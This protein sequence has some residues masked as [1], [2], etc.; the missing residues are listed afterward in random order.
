MTRT[1]LAALVLAPALL[2]GL[3]AAAEPPPAPEPP[4]RYVQDRWRHTRDTATLGVVVGGLG[5]ATAATGIALRD[6]D[7]VPSGFMIGTGA[8]AAA[9]GATVM[10]VVGLQQRYEFLDRANSPVGGY[11]GL[12]MVGLAGIG[13][14]G[15]IAT[16]A[17]SEVHET[18]LYGSAAIGGTAL[19][20]AALQLASNSSRFHSS[21]PRVAWGPQITRDRVG[22]VAVVRW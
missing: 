14:I 20:P 8:L 11:L 12:G 10:G 21:R 7:S 13:M 17:D 6:E 1:L 19:I 22:A 4:E 18:L 3:A 2:P 9:S 16:P 15:A 5:V